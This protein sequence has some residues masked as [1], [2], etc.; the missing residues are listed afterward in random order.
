MNV[1]VA[2]VSMD[3]NVVMVSH[4]AIQLSSDDFFKFDPYKTEGLNNHG[5]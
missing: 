4:V 1:N 2:Q 5:S 3:H